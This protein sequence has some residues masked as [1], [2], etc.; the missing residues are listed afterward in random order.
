M[1]DIHNECHLMKVAEKIE[2]K[3]SCMAEG[4][5]FKYRQLDIEPSEFAAATKAIERLIRKGQVK[6][7]SRGVFYTPRYS[8]FGEL[9][10]SDAELLKPYLFEKGK[11]IAYITGSALYNR[12]GLTTQLPNNIQVASRVKRIATK[13]G[14][15]RVKPV[16]SYVDVSDE[17]YT[18]L[19]TLDALKDFRTISDLDDEVFIRILGERINALSDKKMSEL[20]AYALNYPPRV[21]AL[22]GALLESLKKDTYLDDLKS[23]L[24]P[25]TS[26]NLNI[27]K[28]LLPT[29]VNWNIH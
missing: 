26:Y 22:L 1:L 21:K 4:T 25:L 20:I 14:K 16:K 24:N 9:K 5:T 8:V 2:R 10:P 12:M 28:E 23:G 11:R 3:V 13:I 15:T 27:D 6:R 7:I 19:E 18:L 29:A 17:N